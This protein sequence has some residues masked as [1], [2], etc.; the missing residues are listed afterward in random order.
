MTRRMG[1]SAVHPGQGICL[2][3]LARS[4]GVTQRDLAAAMHVAPPTL[5]RMLRSMERAGLVERR[6]DESDQRLT[7]VYLSDAGRALAGRAR[8]ALA[9]HIPAA[10]AALS[11]EER[12]ELVRLLDK[13]NESVARSLETDPET[14]GRAGEAGRRPRDGRGAA[15]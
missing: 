1:E 9:D 14:A 15:E 2:T 5:S 12:A 10:M 4:D 6:A 13:L 11:R 8:A 3:I 7:R